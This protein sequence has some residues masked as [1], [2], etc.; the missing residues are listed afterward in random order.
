MP[1]PHDRYTSLTCTTAVCIPHP[2]TVNMTYQR[3]P[4]TATRSNTVYTTR[5][6]DLTNTIILCLNMIYLFFTV[7]HCYIFAERLRRCRRRPSGF[8][9]KVLRPDHHQS[10]K[11]YNILSYRNT[12]R[13]YY[14]YHHYYFIILLPRTKYNYYSLFDPYGFSPQTRVPRSTQAPTCV[15]T[16]YNIPVSFESPV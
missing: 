8:R 4:E 13:L 1:T 9:H 12:S 11:R 14:Y 6:C 15:C 5:F 16:Y 3:R 7:Q 10:L 2:N